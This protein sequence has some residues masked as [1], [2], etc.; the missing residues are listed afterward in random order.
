MGKGV[1]HLPRH[2]PAACTW[3]S[4]AHAHGHRAVGGGEVT[5]PERTAVNRKERP[6]WSPRKH[7]HFTR[8]CA[9]QSSTPLDK[10]AFLMI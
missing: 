6:G 9:L 7:K 4:P 1:V 10:I 2:T 5:V 8:V 3:E